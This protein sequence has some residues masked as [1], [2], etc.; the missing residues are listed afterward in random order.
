M[1]TAALLAAAAALAAAS[2][3]NAQ[4]MVNYTWAVSDT[5][6]ANGLIEPGES[7]VFTLSAQIM[8]A[9][10]AYFAGSIF[11]VM[12]TGGLETGSYTGMVRNPALTMNPVG[13]GTADPLGNISAVDV[14]QL[15]SFMNPLAVTANPITLYTL[16]WQPADYT[17]R[18]VSG[19]GIHL[20][21]QIYADPFAIGATDAMAVPGGFAAQVVPAPGAAALLAVAGLTAA[22]RR[23]S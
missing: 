9:P 14:F 4:S 8:A 23:R 18:A 6:N 1:R 20:T 7:G 19:A 17:P 12:N 15:S 13:S 10:G 16:T 3:A 21:S 2:A 11:N 5:G 22:R